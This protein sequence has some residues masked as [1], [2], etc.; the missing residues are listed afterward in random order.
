M[1][2]W[3]LWPK[4]EVKSVQ[5]V[6]LKLPN[7]KKLRVLNYYGI[8][9][10]GKIG[11]KETLEACKKINK[12]AT[13]VNYPTI[14]TGDFNLFPDTESMK[15]F[16]THFIS[17]VDQ[18]NIQTTRPKSNELNHLKR[19]VVDFI[20]INKEVKVNSFEVLDSDVSDH[21]PL[22]LDFGL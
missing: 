22:I 13:E 15:V 16:N 5:V 6:D 17:L 9:T 11:N 10:K 12:L 21:L 14:I 18:H 8:W 20:L 3:T 2:D 4:N 19:N 7:S 1:T